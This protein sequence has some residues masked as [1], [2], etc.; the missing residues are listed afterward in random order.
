MDKFIQKILLLILITLCFLPKV[1]FAADISINTSK[2][3]FSLG[4]D[5]LVNIFADTK[6]TS[7]NAIEGTLLFSPEF[8]ELKEIRDGNSAINFWVEKP[9]STENDKVVFS[10]ITTGGF[11]GKNEF[12]FSLVFRTKKTGDSNI[13]FKDVQI[14]ENDGAGTKLPVNTS[15]FK[16]SISSEVNRSNIDNFKINDT[17]PPEDFSPAIASDPELFD[18]KYFL[19]F[20]TV[21]KGSGIDHYEVYESQWFFGGNNANQYVKAESPY[22]LKDQTLKSRIYVK[23]VDKSG[24]ERI[25]KLEA[26][27]KFG[28]FLQF[29]IIGIIL[30]ICIFFL[31]KILSKFTR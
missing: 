7:V 16:F 2:N 3:S 1:S 27:N 11:S 18:G 28:Y 15:S 8:L 17:S 21:D 14:L 6:D 9:H 24:N 10:G 23:A 25:V 31:K 30:T 4:E 20:S 29:I 22:L 5:F 12:L 13:S 19:V 26:Q